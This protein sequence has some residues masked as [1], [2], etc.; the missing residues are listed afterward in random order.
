MRKIFPIVVF[1]ILIISGIGA[2]SYLERTDSNSELSN[3]SEY[4]ILSDPVIKEKVE[5]HLLLDFEE[6]NS[7]IN[8]IGEPILPIISKRYVFPFG[9]KIEDIQISFS[10]IKEYGLSNKIKSGS[11]PV[12]IV[13]GV[14][15]HIDKNE[16]QVDVYNINKLYPEKHYSIFYNAGL[17]DGEHVII[18]NLECYPIQYNPVENKIYSAGKL[19]I[20]ILFEPSEEPIVYTDEYDLVIIAPDIFSEDLQP[21]ID[22]KNSFGINTILKT[23]ESI[24]DEYDGR[25]QPEQIKYFIKDAIE[26]WD[27]TYVLLVGGKKSLI[28]DDDLWHVPVRYAN[29]YDGSYP[30]DAHPY[31]IGFLSD[32]YFADIYKVKNDE[33]VFDD[34]DSDNNDVFAE[35]SLDNKD[36]IDFYPDVYV[37]RLACRN[38][39]EVQIM[40]DKII[41]YE[42]E[43]TDPSWFNNIV[44]VGG[45]SFDGSGGG[46]DWL[47]GEERNQLAFDYLSEFNPVR[48]WASN[49]DT[50]DPVP[51]RADIFKA[52]ND[53]CGFIYFAGHSN[54][55]SW[56]TYWYHDWNREN[57]T[58]SFS[59]YSMMLGFKNKEKLP[60][61]VIGSC[62]PLKFNVSFLSFINRQTE[63]FPIPECLGWVFTRN[64]D[65]GSI[66]TIGYTQLEWV[67]TWGWDS[68]DDGIPDCTQYVS[69]Y[70]DVGIWIV[71]SSMHMG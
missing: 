16:D 62:E 38:N 8:N 12:I 43:G 50:G 14:E 69:G 64:P 13:D 3:Q 71:D 25:D 46:Y 59:I 21:L 42:S 20:D 56:Q 31:G 49:K 26:N 17:E 68:V 61:C 28:L 54:P 52:I 11:S 48:V 63:S 47:E 39:N 67:A 66:A 34:W 57:F 7:Y 60:V 44:G 23:T 53:G 40:V 70:L 36:I 37:G 45:D 29:I 41:T 24:Y 5:G 9:T 51:S 35:W 27:I 1:L 10:D 58:E 33:I 19:D 32:L 22:H 2:G 30:Y 65:G 6:S 4:I 15:T 18:I 55:A